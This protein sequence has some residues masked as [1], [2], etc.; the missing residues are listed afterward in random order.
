MIRWPCLLVLCVSTSGCGDAATPD[1]EPADETGGT[2]DTSPSSETAVPES[3]GGS[4]SVAPSSDASSTEV[5]TPGGDP[6]GVCDPTCTGTKMCDD[7]GACVCA[8]GWIASGKDCVAAPVS[9][10]S[11]RTKAEVCA[12]YKLDTARPATLWK[13]GSGGECDPGTVPASAQ[14]AALRYLNFYRWMIGVGPVQVVPAVAKAEQECAKILNYA[15][16]HSPDP[17][18]KCYTADGAAACGDSLIA[19]G[20]DLMT[21]FDGYGLEIDQNL[22]H[23]RNVLAVGRAGVW[24]GASGGSSDM[25]YGGAYPALASDP[26]FVAHPGPGPNVRSKVPSR[27]FVQKGTATIAAVD[28]HV[29]VVS[30]GEEK[31]MTRYHHYTDFSSFDVKGWTPAVDVAYRVE[32]VD[33]TGKKVATYETSFVDCP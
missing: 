32:L 4:D 3:D 25:H 12:R 14:M 6:V 20:F 11:T 21:Q 8:P 31:P 13:P 7:A 30:T 17:S 1:S 18:T 15:F 33:D 19:G 27:W 22:I 5:S 26:A 16:G 24:T 10:P 9:A 29:Y 23:R 28:A 2:S